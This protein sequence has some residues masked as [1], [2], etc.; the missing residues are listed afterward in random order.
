MYAA[1]FTVN[2]IKAL[3]NRLFYSSAES[4][5]D[6]LSKCQKNETDVTFGKMTILKLILENERTTRSGDGPQR[7]FKWEENWLRVLFVREFRYETPANLIEKLDTDPITFITFN[8]D[9]SFEYFIFEAI[10][11][12][13]DLSP[14]Q[15]KNIFSKIKIHHVYGSLAPLEWQDSDLNK[16]L[17][18]GDNLNG[19][20][21]NEPEKLYAC[22]SNINVINEDRTDF[23]KE[24]QEYIELIKNSDKV[25]ILGFGFHTSNYKILGIEEYKNSRPQKAIEPDKFI[26]TNYK[27]SEG[28]KGEIRLGFG[29][30]LG[31]DLAQSHNLNIHDYMYHQY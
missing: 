6:F 20:Y 17:K 14:E 30:T 21:S 31:Y 13:Y 8:Y 9:R 1:D 28:R 26:Y 25:F 2:K 15:A 18:F 16:I 23:E 11:H 5:D 4:I 22:S 24:Q 12:Y 7:L 19:V 27:I 29:T 3:S 10:K